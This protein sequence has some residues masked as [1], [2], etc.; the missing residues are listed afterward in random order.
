MFST[1]YAGVVIPV[2]F[3]DRDSFFQLEDEI[4]LG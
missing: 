3:L 1:G 2:L 4:S